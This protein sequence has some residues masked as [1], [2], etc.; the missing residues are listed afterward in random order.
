MPR[1]D[2]GFDGLVALVRAYYV[3]P[4]DMVPKLSRISK[5]A[6][7]RRRVDAG[8]YAAVQRAIDGERKPK[9]RP[10]EPER[11]EMIAAAVT[12]LHTKLGLKL[13]GRGGAFD[14]VAAAFGL[15]RSRAERIY[16]DL[17]ENS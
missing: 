5:E 7:L 8:D 17:R 13:T 12:A 16:Y 9:G 3:G 1:P 4:A 6:S 15:S 14:A 2:V 11:Q 10:P